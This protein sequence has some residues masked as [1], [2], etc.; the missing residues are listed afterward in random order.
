MSGTQPEGELLIG[1]VW[2]RAA[3]TLPAENPSTGAVEGEIARG[4]AADIDEA[5]AAAR[6][7]VAEL[8]RAALAQ[9]RRVTR[10]MASEWLKSK[11]AD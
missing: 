6:A 3:A 10:A 1:G 8:D 2:R 11:E 5:V 7:A 9:G 4:T